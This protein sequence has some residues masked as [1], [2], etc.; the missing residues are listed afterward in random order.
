MLLRS[1]LIK[2]S[3]VNFR[4]SNNFEKK[5][6]KNIQNVQKSTGKSIPAYGFKKFLEKNPR[7]KI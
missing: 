6:M 3:V 5:I 2:K 4:V 1:S 7:P